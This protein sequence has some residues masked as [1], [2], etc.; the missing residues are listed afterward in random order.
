[1]SINKLSYF[2]QLTAFIILIFTSS[3]AQT[4]F[5]VIGDF[6]DDNA[7]EQAVADFPAEA[8][9]RKPPQVPYTPWHLLEHLRLP[10]GD[11]GS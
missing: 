8:I 3:F 10:D 4:K 6:G 7:D 1:M 5:A 11:V 2:S 9:N